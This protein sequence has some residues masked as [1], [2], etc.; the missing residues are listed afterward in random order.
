MIL[1]P[2]STYCNHAG[3]N[4]AVRVRVG[5]QTSNDFHEHQYDAQFKPYSGALR[6]SDSLQRRRLGDH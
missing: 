5:N 2:D 6:W 4:R 3:G 1:P